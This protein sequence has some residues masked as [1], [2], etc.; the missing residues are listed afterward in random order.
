MPRVVQRL[1]VLVGDRA[2]L[3]ILEESCVIPDFEIIEIAEHVHLALH[4]RGLPQNR[5][6]QDAPLRVQLDDLPVVIRARQ[7][8]SAS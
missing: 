7:K 3:Q 1:E 4:L 2:G 5:L 6:H 8:L